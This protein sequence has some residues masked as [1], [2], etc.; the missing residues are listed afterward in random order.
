MNYINE[1]IIENSHAMAHKGFCN[2][3]SCMECPVQWLIQNKIE[4]KTVDSCKPANVKIAAKKIIQYTEHPLL[5]E[6]I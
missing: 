2:N 5:L 3:V 6:L 4:V 1:K